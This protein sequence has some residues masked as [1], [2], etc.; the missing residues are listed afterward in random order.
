M[1]RSHDRCPA[2]ICQRNVGGDC[3]QQR[4]NGQEETPGV[5]CCALKCRCRSINSP[6]LSWRVTLIAGRVQRSFLGRGLQLVRSR[7]PV[8]RLGR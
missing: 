4:Y 3:S 7:Y 1:D 2:A 6:S 5:A 8:L